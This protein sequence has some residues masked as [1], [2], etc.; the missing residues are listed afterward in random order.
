MV[1]GMLSC[2]VVLM[3]SRLQVMAER[4]PGMMRGLHMIARLV[5]F[6]GFAMVFGSGF[7]MLCCLFVML[8]N[9]HPV[10]PEL[11]WRTRGYPNLNRLR[12]RQ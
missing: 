5:V 3:L 10:L 12:I 8:V 4:N 11:F 1:F 6:G 7:V 9:L 2:G